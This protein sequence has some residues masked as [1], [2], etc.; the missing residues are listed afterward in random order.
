MLAVD[1]ERVLVLAIALFG[2]L[3]VHR[4][5]DLLDGGEG[6]AAMVF[7]AIALVGWIGFTVGAARELADRRRSRRADESSESHGLPRPAASVHAPRSR[8]ARRRPARSE[9]ETGPDRRGADHE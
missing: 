4:A 3:A 5:L 8:V 6:S 7:S 1:R 9:D 2:L